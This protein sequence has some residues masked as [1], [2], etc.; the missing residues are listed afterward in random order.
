[1]KSSA[2]LQN[3]IKS[4]AIGSFDGIHIAHQELIKKADGVVVIER[5]VATLTPG[6]KRSIYTKKPTFFYML[7]NIKNLSPKEFIAKIE[8]NFPNLKKIVVGYD[9]VFG[10]N[11]SGTIDSLKKYFSG[12]VE[13]IKEIKLNGISVHSR[14]IR[15]YIKNSN[16]ELAN[17]MLGRYYLI[18]GYHIK[19]QGLGAK[20]LVPTINLKVVNYTLPTGVFVVNAKINNK[21]YRAISFVGHR[22]S[23]D[24]NFALEVHILENFNE[25]IRG[26]VLIE[27]VSFIRDNRKFSSLDK[28]KKQILKDIEFVRKFDYMI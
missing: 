15:E 1:L 26:K 11:K 19:G 16:I 9:F 18:D 22:E 28:L 27:F 2:H 17:S 7:D 5:S 14:V 12:K 6:W 20:E 24:N 4:I 23:T 10:K 3:S 21:S 25:N 13:V 8:S